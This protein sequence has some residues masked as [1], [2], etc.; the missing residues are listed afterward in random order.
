MQISNLINS[1]SSSSSSDQETPPS[2]DTEMTPPQETY[3]FS[4]NTAEKAAKA[5][6][7]QPGGRRHPGPS[8]RVRTVTTPHSLRCYSQPPPSS[9]SSSSSSSST[10]LPKAHL[11]PHHACLRCR[12]ARMPCTPRGPRGGCARCHD[13]GH[14]CEIRTELLPRWSGAIAGANAAASSSSGGGGG[15]GGGRA[16]LQARVVRVT[17]LNGGGTRVGV[18]LVPACRCPVR[19]ME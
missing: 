19:I 10:S 17:D 6:Q 4:F 13:H 5:H 9:S 14:A 16:M 3:G 18:R 2:E 1:S 11:L 7:Q 15:G 12:R 8:T